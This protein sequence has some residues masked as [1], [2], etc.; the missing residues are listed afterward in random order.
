MAID[1][2]KV[3]TV[4]VVGHASSGKTSLVDTALFMAKAVDRHGRV[5]QGTSAADNLPDEIERKITI[6]A[7]PL[8]C[9]WQDYQICLLDTPG[10][11]DFYGETMAG[12][13]AG[14]PASVGRE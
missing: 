14:D 5:A 6:H 1:T 4:A 13:R 3:R 2:S 9:Q 12:G 8:Y 11:A 10:L 7:K